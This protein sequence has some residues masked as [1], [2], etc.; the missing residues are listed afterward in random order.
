MFGTIIFISMLVA[1]P[2]F[3][4]GFLLARRLYRGGNA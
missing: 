4:G 2:S 3:G 1:V